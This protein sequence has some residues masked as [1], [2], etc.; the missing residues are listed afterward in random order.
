MKVTRDVILDLWPVYEAGEASADTRAL[1]E[2]FLQ[3]D[4]EFADLV[5]S[6]SPLPAPAQD[7]PALSRDHELETLRKT[8]RLLLL[9]QQLLLLGL[10]LIMASGIIRVF[11]PFVLGAS[12]LC[13]LASLA[14]TLFGRRL[15]R[16]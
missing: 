11:R 13:F 4:P 1:V 3:D 16:L 7:V 9:R 10:L 12:V 8:Q 5:Q 6:R 2:Q 15:F 14:L